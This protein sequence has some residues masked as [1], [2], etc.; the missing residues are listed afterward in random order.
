MITIEDVYSFADDLYESVDEILNNE[1]SS[2]GYTE[3]AAYS[4]CE[5]WTL[6]CEVDE[7]MNK[8]PIDL[9]YEAIDDW[10]RRNI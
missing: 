1:G 6:C 5:L 4:N 3:V 8:I 9:G 7:S 2:Y 10:K